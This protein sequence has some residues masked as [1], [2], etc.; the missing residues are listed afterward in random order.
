MALRCA[1]AHSR[2]AQLSR[3]FLNAQAVQPGCKWH[4]AH[5]RNLQPPG[6]RQHDFLPG[7]PLLGRK[8]VASVHLV[9]LVRT[10]RATPEMQ[11]Q[12]ILMTAEYLAALSD[13]DWA[14]WFAGAADAT[15]VTFTTSVRTQEV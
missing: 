9:H 7:H 8:L 1:T 4:P 14:Y 11:N 3:K 12:A 2:A 5:T 10:E 6:V 15:T 13:V